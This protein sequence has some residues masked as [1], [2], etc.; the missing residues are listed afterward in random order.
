MRS[1]PED[2]INTP[3]DIRPAGQDYIL[4]ATPLLAAM[5]RGHEDIARILLDHGAVCDLSRACVKQLEE[6]LQTEDPNQTA[7]VRLSGYFLQE[8]TGVP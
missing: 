2:T 4:H 3:S 8:K 5:V 1:G 6:L 7:Q